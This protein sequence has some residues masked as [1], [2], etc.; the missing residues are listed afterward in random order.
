MT[1]FSDHFS[2]DFC[3]GFHCSCMLCGQTN[4][5]VTLHVVKWLCQRRLGGTVAVF[6]S[7]VNEMQWLTPA[8]FQVCCSLTVSSSLVLQFFCTHKNLSSEG[9]AWHDQPSYNQLRHNQLHIINMVTNQPCYTQ[10]VTIRISPITIS[11]VT[12]NFGTISMVTN[13][14]DMIRISLITISLLQS[15]VVQST[16]LQV[17][18]VTFNLLQ[19]ESASLQSALLESTRHKITLVIISLVNFITIKLSQSE[20]A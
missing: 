6:S 18:L 9:Q 2:L 7:T 5:C 4:G 12:I 17:S 15:T 19:P 8:L 1:P 11:H 3:A 13:Q 16:W 10:P 14:L 20:S